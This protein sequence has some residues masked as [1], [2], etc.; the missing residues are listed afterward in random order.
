MY[1]HSSCVRT[2]QR[3]HLPCLLQHFHS[4]IVS[5]VS[6]IFAVHR[7]NRV[8]DVQLLSAVGR[9]R[10]EDL[11]D[12]D[13]HLVFLAALDADAQSIVILLRNP[14]HSS[15]AADDGVGR[16][17]LVRHSARVCIAGQVTARIFV[18]T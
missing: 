7:E 1:T 17:E 11:A 5:G 4:L 14:H 15:L 10:L 6:Q 3:D 18:R 8:A 9:H 12:E 13:R 2:F 16:V